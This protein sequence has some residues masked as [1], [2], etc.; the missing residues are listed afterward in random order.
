ML[1]HCYD[2]RLRVR[3]LFW[4]RSSP[5]YGSSSSFFYSNSQEPPFGLLPCSSF[6]YPQEAG[7]C[8]GSD[9]DA[10]QLAQLAALLPHHDSP[11]PPPSP[12]PVSS[13]KRL[14]KSAH[15]PAK[16]R[17]GRSTFLSVLAVTPGPPSLVAG[18][19]AF[20]TPQAVSSPSSQLIPP[21]FFAS[22]NALQG[23]ISSL[24]QHLQSFSSIAATSAPSAIADLPGA[25]AIPQPLPPVFT[26]AEA[27]LGSSLGR[28]YVPKHANV[29]PRLRSKIL[30]GQYI[31]LVS[32]IMPSPEVDHKIASSE[33]HGYF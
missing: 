24:T 5:R 22:I 29:S 10:T 23:S 16:R 28:S 4:S 18:P 8:P 27:R 9:L 3:R 2:V 25:Q 30:Q 7:I 14:R 31:N 33:L 17:R 19:S 26:L 6:S 15:P 13:R 1:I 32:L 21:V 20:L 12:P 11:L